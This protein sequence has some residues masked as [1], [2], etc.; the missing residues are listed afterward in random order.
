MLADGFV[1]SIAASEA[2]LAKLAA[3][4]GWLKRRTMHSVVDRREHRRIQ[5]RNPRSVILFPDNST[6]SCFIIDYS[7]SGV[8]VS[9][10]VTP[11]IG[12]PIAVGTLVGQV[13][14]LLDRGFAVRFAGLQ[15]S[16]GLED[17]LGIHPGERNAVLARLS[18][19]AAAGGLVPTQ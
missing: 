10:D 15:E 19:F 2:R 18:A 13:I 6:L 12:A 16:E 9:A 7:L 1:M 3:T 4:I 14:R 8:A 5:P 11:A 17:R